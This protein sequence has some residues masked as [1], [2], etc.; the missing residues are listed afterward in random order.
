MHTDRNTHTYKHT[1]STQNAYSTTQVQTRKHKH[2]HTSTH[3]HTRTRSHKPHTQHKLGTVGRWVRLLLPSP[4]ISHPQTET[5]GNTHPSTNITSSG[6]SPSRMGRATRF[7]SNPG[8][9]FQAWGH[10]GSIAWVRFQ[11]WSSIPTLGFDSNPGV[12]FQAWGSIAS[13]GS[14]PTLGLDSKPGNVCV[15]VRTTA[16]AQLPRSLCSFAPGALTDDGMVWEAIP[17][18][19]GASR[20]RTASDLINCM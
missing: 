19:P 6:P 8:V 17:S 18:Q 1:R 5:A 7:E 3:T 10:M 16:P 13:L 4:S 20:E 12:R 15:H 11:P 2:K 9:R 14:N